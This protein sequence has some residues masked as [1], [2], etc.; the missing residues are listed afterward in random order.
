MAFV[1]YS[2]VPLTLESP[3]WCYDLRKKEETNK[4]S[5]RISTQII[6]INKDSG[7]EESL[8]SD[9]EDK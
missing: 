2:T 1:K 8:K 3:E 6:R 4:K 7:E 9:L 5:H